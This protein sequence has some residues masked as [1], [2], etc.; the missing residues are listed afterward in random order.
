MRGRRRAL[1]ADEH[2]GCATALIPS[3]GSSVPRATSSFASSLTNT[4]HSSPP[5]PRPRPA[6]A[7]GTATAEA[8]LA[9]IGN[10]DLEKIRQSKTSEILVFRACRRLG[11]FLRTLSASQIEIAVHVQD[12]YG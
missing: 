7:C 3:L 6:S 1:E 11:F 9:A 12:H 10:A 4:S 5:R 2:G 8:R